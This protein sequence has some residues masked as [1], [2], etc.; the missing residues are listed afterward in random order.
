MPYDPISQR[1]YNL[2][3]KYRITPQECDELLAKQEGR[4]AIC[5]VHESDLPRRLSVDHDHRTGEVRGLLCI[6][7]N[8]NL[9][10]VEKWSN[11]QLRDMLTY[12]EGNVG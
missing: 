2:K 1:K 3:N 12:L 8:T 10:V 5:K 7:C 4:C 11:R 9:A 6:K